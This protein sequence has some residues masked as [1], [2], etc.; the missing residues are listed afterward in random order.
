M[1]WRVD[2]RQDFEQLRRGT[3]R[4]SGPLTVTMGPPDG[5]KPPRVAYAIG[6]KVGTAPSRNR[7][8]RRVR[9]LLADRQDRLVPATYLVSARPGAADLSF[10]ELRTFLMNALNALDALEADGHA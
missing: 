5:T 7:L 10:D 1:I 9:A 2:T 8:R 3:R 4:R 6:R